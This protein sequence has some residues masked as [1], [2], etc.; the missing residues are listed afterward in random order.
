MKTKTYLQSLEEINVLLSLAPDCI[1]IAEINDVITRNELI[2]DLQKQFNTLVLSFQDIKNNALNQPLSSD[3]Q[4]N[5][6]IVFDELQNSSAEDVAISLNYNR[7]WLLSLYQKIV[8]LLPTYTVNLIIRYSNNFW[9]CVT[10]YRSFSIKYPCPI[11]PHFI[12]EITNV[13]ESHDEYIRRREIEKRVYNTSRSSF[14]GIVSKKFGINRGLLSESDL[15]KLL[16]DFSSSNKND[17]ICYSFIFSLGQELYNASHYRGALTCFNYIERTMQPYLAK[18]ALIDHLAEAKAESY[19]RLKNYTEA[20]KNYSKMINRPV[21]F[22]EVKDSA[23]IHKQARVLNNLAV[24]SCMLKEYDAAEDVLN[25][26]IEKLQKD[27]GTIDVLYSEVLYNLSVLMCYEGNYEK[28]LEYI[29][30]AISYIVHIKARFYNILTSMYRVLYA[31]IMSSLGMHKEATDAL[32]NSLEL[33]RNELYE[34]N[35]YVLEAHYTNAY[36]FT[37]RNALHQ[38]LHCARKALSISQKIK[39]DG[40][41]KVIIN[42][43]IGEILYYMGDLKAAKRQF[44]YILNRSELNETFSNEMIEWIKTVSELVA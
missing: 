11:T 35:L 39:A 2:E 44:A 22:F 17:A 16:R 36:V 43:L 7:D 4:S 30:A 29:N 34:N 42:E 18:E 40:R 12:D 20:I 3:S 5:T 13:F 27:E 19:Y 37:R 26:V 38:A 10:L 33:L 41:T 21:A 32:S 31:Y 15:S 8:I 9:S 24:I 6:V 14:T 28:A 23:Q 25:V 1:I